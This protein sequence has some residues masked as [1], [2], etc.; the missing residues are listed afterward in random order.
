MVY[1]SPQQIEVRKRLERK[2]HMYLGAIV[3]MLFCILVTEGISIC[4]SLMTL[5]KQDQL[6]SYLNDDMGDNSEERDQE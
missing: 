6:S 1:E 2:A 4:T 3:F 5:Y